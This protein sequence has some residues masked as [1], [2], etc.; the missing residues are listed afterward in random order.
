M[1]EAL[2]YQKERGKRVVCT[3]C[4]HGCI[5]EEGAAGKCRGRENHDGTLY[6]ANYGKTISLGLDPIEKKPLYHF[7]PGEQILSVAANSCNFSCDF[8]Q[9]YEI[10][11]IPARTT[12]ITPQNLLELCK[13]YDCS[14]VAFTYTEPL[15]WYEF[16]LDACS[17]LQQHQIK[18]V[19]VTNGYINP[20]PLA[21]L[22]PVVDAMNI[23]LKAMS[24]LFYR[25]VCGGTLQPVLHTIRAAAAA[26]HVE[27]T[28]LL[29]PGE[30]DSDEDLDALIRFV[31]GVDPRIPLHFSKYFPHYKRETHP[32][33]EA[34]LWHAAEMARAELDFVY[35]GN[36]F[37]P[38]QTRCPQC[39]ELLITRQQKAEVTLNNGCCP[40]CGY[41][42]Y[43]VW[44]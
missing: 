12:A 33:D 6:A 17:F 35:L 30:N 7:L 18:T 20:E 2:Y 23:D 25:S 31:A 38:R 3:L 5:I 13:R 16:V 1:H 15:T 11:Q 41:P 21:Q 44:Q 22:L 19:L 39:D 40:S 27:I 14:M 8:C 4:P 43:G 32:T 36:I 24:E 28:N 34:S 9:N 26:C 29:I 37:T 42:I 10:S